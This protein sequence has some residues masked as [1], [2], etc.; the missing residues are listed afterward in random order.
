MVSPISTTTYTVTYDLGGCIQTT[1]VI[2]TVNPNPAVSITGVDSICLGQS[3]TLTAS[4][5]VNYLWNTNETTQNITVAPT[6][7]TTYSVA[8]INT[9]GCSATASYNVIVNP[10]PQPSFIST[11]VCNGMMTDLVSTSSIASGSITCLLYTSP[12][13]RDLSTSRM[14]SSA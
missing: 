9:N 4:Q 5:S 10:L 3:T 11:A 13:P 1:S 6:T 12:S 14:P 2:V 7:N 8:V